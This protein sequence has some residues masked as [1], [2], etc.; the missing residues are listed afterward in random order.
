MFLVL[1][2]EDQNVPW[3]L[4]MQQISLDRSTSEP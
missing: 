1:A 3:L 4:M 2:F